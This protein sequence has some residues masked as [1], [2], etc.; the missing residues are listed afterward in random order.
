MKKGLFYRKYIRPVK[1]TV[2]LAIIK[3]GIWKIRLFPREISLWFMSLLGS[4]AFFV[5][6]RDRKIA[7]AN[8]SHVFPDK[9]PTEINTFAKRI[10]QNASMNLADTVL[11]RKIIDSE[12]RIW[13]VEGEEYLREYRDSIGGGVVITGHIGCF[14]LIPGICAKIGYKVG[15]VGR[16]LYDS[17]V[18]EILVRQRESLGMVVVPSDASPR[19]LIRLI[20]DGYFIGILM[21]TNTKSVDGKP[22]EF[23]GLQTRTI[24]GPIGL[25]MLLET[26]PLPMAIHREDGNRFVLKIYPPLKLEKSGDKDSDLENGLRSANEAIESMIL[27]CPEEWI[28]FHPKFRDVVNFYSQ[29]N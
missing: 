22:A 6:R 26:P 28:W 10:F 20:R 2:G 12:P 4:F 25:A 29:S 15:V 17:R 19:K 14:E 5:L 24:S 3:I 7:I 13:R 9:S 23:F 1:H 27:D 8:L 21:D 11:A 16:Q 18:D